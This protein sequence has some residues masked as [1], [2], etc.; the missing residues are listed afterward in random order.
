MR[1]GSQS[2]RP[3]DPTRFRGHRSDDGGCFAHSHRSVQGGRH[4]RGRLPGTG[5]DWAAL[6][7]SVS[8][9][10]VHHANC[11]VAVIHDEDPLMPYPAM[12]PSWWEST[13]R[14][15]RS[16]RRRSPSTRHH[17]EAWNSSPSMHGVITG[18]SRFPAHVVGHAG[19]RFRRDSGRAVGGMARA[20][21][22]RDGSTCRGPRTGRRINCSSSRSPRN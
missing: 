18:A 16:P 15:R 22:G 11:P 20:L 6:L 5:R 13:V 10:L 2:R 17:A 3:R 4:N 1:A 9:G 7:G 12:A 19:N 21:P 14:R 8:W